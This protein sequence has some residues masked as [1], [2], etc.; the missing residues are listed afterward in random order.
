MGKG[1][2]G[3]PDG[4]VRKR[5]MGDS[6]VRSTDAIFDKFL[7]ESGN[8]VGPDPVCN[9]HY[10]MNRPMLEELCCECYGV[11]KRGTDRLL[12]RTIR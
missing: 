1:C 3:L 9:R 10:S 4:S 8:A 5:T 7:Y 12:P 11:V 6:P 2:A